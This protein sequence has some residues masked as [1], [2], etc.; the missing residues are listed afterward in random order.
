MINV[1]MSYDNKAVKTTYRVCIAVL[2]SGSA[3]CKGYNTDKIERIIQ[4]AKNFRNPIRLL[5]LK[6]SESSVVL[7]RGFRARKN[8]T[9][10][11]NECI[12]SM[13][14]LFDWKPMD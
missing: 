12:A 6:G 4:K 8:V 1:S 7:D 5:L 9:I 14:T 3:L 11:C 2:F 10:R 13:T